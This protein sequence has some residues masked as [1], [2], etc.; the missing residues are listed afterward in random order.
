MFGGR[1]GEQA[2]RLGEAGHGRD[3]CDALGRVDALR[4]GFGTR[5]VVLF[6]QVRDRYPCEVQAAV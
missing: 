2:R 4:V 6:F 5:D 1:V 3:Q